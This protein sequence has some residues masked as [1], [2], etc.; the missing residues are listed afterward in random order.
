MPVKLRGSLDSVSF[1]PSSFFMGAHFLLNPT[2]AIIS[3]VLE[4]TI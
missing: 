1:K 3:E 4:L 2:L